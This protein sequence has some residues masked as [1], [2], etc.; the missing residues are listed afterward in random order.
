MRGFTYLAKFLLPRSRRPPL[1]AWGREHS[2]RVTGE[3]TGSRR[4]L[5]DDGGDDILPIAQLTYSLT[6]S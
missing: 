6:T 5:P 2:S 1:T 3:S 4:L